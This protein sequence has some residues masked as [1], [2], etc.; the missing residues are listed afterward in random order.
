MVYISCLVIGLSIDNA[1]A[2]SI[3]H[4]LFILKWVS[5]F[6]LTEAIPVIFA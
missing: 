2:E 1:F 6:F 3:N 5:I 4:G